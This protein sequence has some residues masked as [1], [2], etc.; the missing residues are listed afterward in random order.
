VQIKADDEWAS[1][2]PRR[3]QL[4]VEWATKPLMYRYGYAGRR[5]GDAPHRT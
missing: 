3:D 4:F 2:M 1:R 5:T